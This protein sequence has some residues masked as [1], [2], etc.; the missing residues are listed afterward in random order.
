MTNLIN[1]IIASAMTSSVVVCLL[2][3]FSLQLI[4]AEVQVN[5]NQRTL[6]LAL[7]QL[8]VVNTASD[9]VI[10]LKGYDYYDPNVRFINN[11]FIY[12]K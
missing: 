6:P 12:N 8:I 1:R 4:S 2:I 3:I 11:Y 5:V 10:R 7:H 9:V